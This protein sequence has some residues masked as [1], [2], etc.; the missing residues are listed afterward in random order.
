M[1][2]KIDVDEEIEKIDKQIERMNMQIKFEENEQRYSKIGILTSTSFISRY[3]N[4]LETVKGYLIGIKYA[5][6]VNYG[7]DLSNL[8]M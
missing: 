1:G 3:I 8:E 7:D 6:E 4:Y 2:V 5:R